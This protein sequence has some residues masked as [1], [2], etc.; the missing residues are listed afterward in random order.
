[1]ETNKK[2]SYPLKF[3]PVAMRKP[4]GGDSLIR[5]LGKSFVE[6][7]EDGNEHELTAKDKIGESWELADMGFV[8]SAVGEGWLAGN[9]IGDLMETYLE[10]IVGENVYPYYG[11]QFPVLV[12]FLD[13]KGRTS[14]QVN[15]DDEVAG[16]RYDALGKAKLWYIMEA[17][18]EAKL[19]LGFNRDVSAGEFY[20]RCKNGTLEE[21]LNTVRPEKG[22][23]YFIEPGTVHSAGDGLLVAEIQESS[24]LTFRLYDWGREKKAEEAR[25]MHLEEAFDIIDFCK[26]DGRRHKETHRECGHEGHDGCKCHEGHGKHD[27]SHGEEDKISTRIAECPQFTVTKINLSDPLHIYTDQFGSFII[28]VCVEGSASVQVPSEDGKGNKKT[29]R[30][31]LGKGETILIP[32]DMSDFFLVPEDRETVLLETMLEEQEDID[33]YIDPDTEPYVEGE[34]YEGLDTDE[35]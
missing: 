21:V 28:Y 31:S 10:D 4:W 5:K 17:S 3:I 27:R 9:T 12:K 33:D 19:F 23:S 32:A 16:Q 8:D 11:R 20:D 24:D 14:V 22:K 15:P 35:K 34:D 1:M 6:C 13:I 30:Y 25:D 2:K 29:E 26:Y 7:D 18:P